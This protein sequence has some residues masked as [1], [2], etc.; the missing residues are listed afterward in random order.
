MVCVSF[1]GD[2][3]LPVT[4][5]S[6]YKEGQPIDAYWN[7]TIEPQCS[8]IFNH[9]NPKKKKWAVI[10]NNTPG[11]DKW[12]KNTELAQHLATFSIGDSGRCLKKLL[13]HW[14][15]MPSK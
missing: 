11:I 10:H 8:F 5:V 4:M 6:Q 3:S 13:L 2:H 7:F 14:E 15:K 9:F 1:A 12:Q